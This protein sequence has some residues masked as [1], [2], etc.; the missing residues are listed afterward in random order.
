MRGVGGD[1]RGK[2]GGGGNEGGG[3]RWILLF[4]IPCDECVMGED[5]LSDGLLLYAIGPISSF[6]ECT[7]CCD[8]Y[9]HII[10]A[11]SLFYGG[12]SSEAQKQYAQCKQPL[13]VK[14]TLC[15]ISGTAACRTS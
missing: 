7:Y 4:G 15:Y 3:G 13:S 10:K 5:I 11:D 8:E 9:S 2:D 1:G 14:K 12:I 6:L